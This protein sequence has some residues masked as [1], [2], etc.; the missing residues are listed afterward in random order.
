MW[1]FFSVGRGIPRSLMAIYRCA[2]RIY[3]ETNYLGR[4]VWFML[5]IELSGM[6]FGLK[7]YVWFQ[8]RTSTQLEFNLKSQV[9]CQTKIALHSVQLPLYFVH[10]H[11]Q[12]KCKAKFWEQKLQNSPHNGFLCLSFSCNSLGALKKPWNLTGCFVLVFLSYCLGQKVWFR[13]ENSCAI[14]E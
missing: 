14:W 1:F 12:R 13:A 9:W 7:S 3:D 4:L 10:F 11:F 2:F 5:V 8:N 6:Q